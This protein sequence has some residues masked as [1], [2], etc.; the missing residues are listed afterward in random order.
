MG[1]SISSPKQEIPN[2]ALYHHHRRVLPLRRADSEAQRYFGPGTP[3]ARTQAF[4][5]IS[6]NWGLGERCRHHMTQ[7]SQHQM[8]TDARGIGEDSGAIGAVLRPEEFQVCFS[9]TRFHGYIMLTYPNLG[10]EM[11]VKLS[12]P[13][14]PTFSKPT[15]SS[16]RRNCNSPL[17]LP[18][19]LSTSSPLHPGV[20]TL[21]VTPSVTRMLLDVRG[22]SVD[23]VANL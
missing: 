13:A 18:S 22:I 14:A 15:D 21:N 3:A 23:L 9:L 4:A 20:T 19:A 5:R 7:D 16:S 6:K 11:L 1:S 2:I 17:S 10:T 12:N 8:I